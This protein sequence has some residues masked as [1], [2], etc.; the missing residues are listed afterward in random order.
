MSERALEFSTYQWAGLLK[1]LR[2]MLIAD[3]PMEEGELLQL[4]M[5]AYESYTISFPFVHISPSFLVF[6]S[7]SL[8]LSQFACTLGCT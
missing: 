1:H 6:L 2:Q 3:A 4:C 5:T 8:F 7:P